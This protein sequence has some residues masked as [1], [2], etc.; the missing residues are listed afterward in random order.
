MPTPVRYPGM[1]SDRLSAFEDASVYLGGVKAG[2]TDLARLALVVSLAFGTDW[3]LV[4]FPLRYGDVARVHSLSLVDTFATRIAVQPSRD[5]GRQDG[6]SSGA[7]RSMTARRWPTCSC[8]RP[9]SA[10]LWKGRRWRRSPSSGTRW[11]TWLGVE[12]V[13]QGPSGEPVKRGLVESGHCG[14]SCRRPR[15]RRDR[16]Q[17]DDPRSDHW[18]PFVS[19]SVRTS[20][21]DRFATE[22][23]RRP[24]GAVS[25][26]RHGRGRPPSRRLAAGRSR[27]ECGGSPVAH[28]RGGGTAGRHRGDQALPARAHEQGGTVLWIGRR[29][30]AGQGDSSGLRFDTALP[31]AGQ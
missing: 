1:P 25:R 5:V 10:T 24:D 18:I 11:P 26:E 3:F 31:P 19:V 21:V 15:R 13:V 2:S 16:L 8:Y 29:E 22:L 12:R 14:S 4:P 28:R 6:P 17:V 7:R 30:Q 20:P 27:G 23:E 9:P